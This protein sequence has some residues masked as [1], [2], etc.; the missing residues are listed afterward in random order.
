MEELKLL[1]LENQSVGAKKPEGNPKGNHGYMMM[2]T[3][4]ML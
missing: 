4:N 1:S 2:P 3:M